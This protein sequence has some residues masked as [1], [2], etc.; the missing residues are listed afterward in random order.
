MIKSLATK[1]VSAAGAATVAISAVSAP[2]EAAVITYTDRTAWQTALTGLGWSATP[3]EQFNTPIPNADSITFANGVV[4]Q[5]SPTSAEFTNEVGTVLGN[6]TYIGFTGYGLS[7][8]YN[9]ITWT[10]PSTRGFGADWVYDEGVLQV[11]IAGQIIN[12]GTALGGS[13]GFLGFISDTP[14]TSAA[15]NQV[16]VTGTVGFRADNLSYAQFNGGDPAVVPTPALLPG[17]IGMGI[18][19]WRKRKG[20]A[21]ES[22]A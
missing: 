11:T 10:F 4:S 13:S 20:E 15:F 5:G 2:A 16:G 9:Q 14:F 19:A 8:V 3:Q 7:D 12:F 21:A 6:G 1:A 17:L 18:A 22:E